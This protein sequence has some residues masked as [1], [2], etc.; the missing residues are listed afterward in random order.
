MGLFCHI[1]ITIGLFAI[2]SCTSNGDEVFRVGLR[3]MVDDM[4][5]GPLKTVD[6]RVIQQ[7][8]RLAAL[9]RRHSH[10]A[11]ALTELTRQYPRQIHVLVALFVGARV[12]IADGIAGVDGK[13]HPLTVRCRIFAAEAPV[14]R[15]AIDLELGD[16]FFFGLGFGVGV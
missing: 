11:V 14:E 13:V 16:L 9:R 12:G 5:R 7:E 4:H 8:V 15:V 1:L 3:I 10:R 6:G 2:Y